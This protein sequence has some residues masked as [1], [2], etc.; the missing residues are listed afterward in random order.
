MKTNWIDFKALRQQLGF[1]QVLQH[2]GVAVK[3]KG[4]Q[5]HGFC[6]LPNH[7]GKRNSPSFSANLERGIFQCF[8]CG[9][10]GNTLE[11]AALM[12]KVDPQNGAA[13]REV[14]LKLQSRFCPEL[15]NEPRKTERPVVLNPEK[16]K[17]SSPALVNQP[18][19]FELQGLDAGHPYLLNRGFTPEIIAYFGLGY[20][21]RGMLKN[22]VAIPLHDANGSLIG[23]AGRVVD[24]A[25]ISED[26][27]RY[28]FPGERKREGKLLVF[29]K[30][31]FLY[32]GHRIQAPI[33]NLIVVEGFTGVWW[34]AQNGLPNVVATMGSDCSE[35]QAELIVS[36]VR[37]S[38]RVL[39]MPDGD[40]AGE[41]YAQSLLMQVSSH[42]LIRWVK[43]VSGEQPADLTSD[44]LRAIVA[45]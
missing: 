1:A 40:S 31:R 45:I 22:R 28:R 42:R 27:P 23:Y 16:P 21:S 6:P 14:A 32:N 41:R 44:Q 4:T 34:L 39:I 9:A 37:P 8:G 43:L 12:E 38:G 33:E 20:C 15:G 7:N 25:A 30:T 35:R 29:R 11:F 17:D 10:K 19:D 24:D 13:L 36:L 18:L 5:H 2:Y 3:S 26:N